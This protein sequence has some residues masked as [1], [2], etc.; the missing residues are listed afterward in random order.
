VIRFREENA[1]YNASMTTISPKEREEVL[2]LSNEYTEQ[3][4]RSIV[5]HHLAH[6]FGRCRR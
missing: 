5:L 4:A 2:N 6:R 1:V 3:G